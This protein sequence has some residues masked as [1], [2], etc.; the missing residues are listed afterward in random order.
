M[1]DVS[2]HDDDLAAL[3]A[4]GPLETEWEAPPAHV[5]DRIAQTIA[6]DAAPGVAATDAVVTPLRPRTR[7]GRSWWLAAAAVVALVTGGAVALRSMT[8]DGDDDEV[9][10]RA[11]L[12]VL[13]GTGTGSAELVEGDGS[14]R[15][16][17]DTT[18]LGAID[19]YY[20]VWLLNEGVTGLISLGPL[21]EDGVY[22]LPAGIDP[23]EFPV[24]DVSI[25]PLDGDPAHSS[26]S[27]LRGQFDL[28]G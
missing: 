8:D 18:G 15:L 26:D 19:G 11:P 22:D 21:R 12:E 10:A 20:E 14:Y 9:L 5:W 3:R 6:A 7:S 4:R 13:A 1:S 24:V 23:V 28:P 17:L 25:E 27:V 2:E 16:R